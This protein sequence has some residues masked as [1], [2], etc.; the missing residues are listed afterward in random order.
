MSSIRNMQTLG[1]AM[2]MVCAVVS[3]QPSYAFAKDT[4]LAT[5]NG[6]EILKKD[7]DN[8]IKTYPGGVK[9]EDKAM[10]SKMI[11]GQMVEEY[12]IDDA[13]AKSKIAESKEYKERLEV[14]R[15][16]LEKQIY[17]ENMLKGKMTDKAVKAEYEGLKKAYSGKTEVRARHILVPTETEAERV[18]KDLNDGKDFAKLATQ[19]SSGPSA[20]NGGDLGYFTEADMVPEFSKAAFALKPGTYTKT[21]V[22]TQFGF[23]VIKVEDKRTRKMPPLAGEVEGSIRNKL[24]QEALREHLEA[25]YKKADIVMYDEKGNPVKAE[26]GKKK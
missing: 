11:L 13:V 23:H 5:V 26:A 1:L 22:K 20:P 19:R 8:V 10:L 3:L 9:E 17:I 6:R 14:L 7:I 18:I 15:T 2:F 25:L 24:G 4:V 16:Q 21:P 12:L